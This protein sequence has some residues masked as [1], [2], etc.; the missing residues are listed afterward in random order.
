M[1]KW[2]AGCLT[3]CLTSLLVWLTQTCPSHGTWGPQAQFSVNSGHRCSLWW[4]TLTWLGRLRESHLAEGFKQD[5]DNPWTVP[6]GS[7]VPFQQWGQAEASRQ[8]TFLVGVNVIRLRETWILESVVWD[9][10]YPAYKVKKTR[11]N[12][13]EHWPPWTPVAPRRT[14]MFSVSSGGISFFKAGLRFLGTWMCLSYLYFPFWVCWVCC[15]LDTC[16]K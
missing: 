6:T 3:H 15:Q 5:E 1:R 13:S 9:L 4:T 10:F 7:I 12:M 14:V 16:F 2:A 11:D 8:G